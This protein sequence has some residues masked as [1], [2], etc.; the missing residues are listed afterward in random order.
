MYRYI[1]LGHLK[2]YLFVHI[3][4]GSASE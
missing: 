1:F 4:V 3:G 2:I